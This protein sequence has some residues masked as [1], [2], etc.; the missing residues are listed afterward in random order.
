MGK[1]VV[2]L[3][4]GGPAMHISEDSG[5]KVPATTPQ[6]TVN[7]L[8]AALERLYQDRGLRERMGEAARE[9]ALQVYHWDRA[10]ER[11]QEIYSR[12]TD[13]TSYNQP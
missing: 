1:P 9:K 11:L 12:V 8:A 2:C 13:T 4:I 3:D 7:D 10:G 6:R 5:I